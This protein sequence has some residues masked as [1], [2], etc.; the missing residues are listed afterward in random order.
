MRVTANR[1]AGCG[2]QSRSYW[3][4][5]RAGKGVVLGFGEAWRL[6]PTGDRPRTPARCWR[7]GPGCAA[8]GLSFTGHG[9]HQRGAGTHQAS[10]SW[11]CRRRPRLKDGSCALPIAC[12]AGGWRWPGSHPNEPTARTITATPPRVVEAVWSGNEKERSRDCS[13]CSCS[14]SPASRSTEETRRRRVH[15]GRR[16]RG[17]FR[18]YCQVTCGLG[19]RS[20]IRARLRP[21]VSREPGR[22]PGSGAGGPGGPAPGRG[23]SW[24]AVWPRSPSPRAHG[25]GSGAR[26]APRRA[27]P[28]PAPR[29]CRRDVTATAT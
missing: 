23:C 20:W 21:G 24:R 15:P 22:S 7:C 17:G 29:R 11:L 19:S 27:T 4:R 3:A 14:Q 28:V 8:K 13:G 6:S 5:I 25:P 18:S 12:Q 16:C 2:E 26:L 9:G 1:F 10:A